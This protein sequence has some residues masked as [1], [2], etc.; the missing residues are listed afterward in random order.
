MI[1]K[2]SSSAIFAIIT[3][4]ICKSAW[5]EFIPS[6]IKLDYPRDITGGI[7]DPEIA[8]SRLLFAWTNQQR[9][10]WVGRLSPFT[11]EIL[12]DQ[13]VKVDTNAVPAYA[14]GNG[15]EWVE[16]ANSPSI[17]Y[18]KY[19]ENGQFILARAYLK[20]GQ[21][22]TVVLA[23]SEGKYGPIGN[24][25]YPNNRPVINYL[26]RDPDTPKKQ[27]TY[28]RYLNA[29][30]SE[31]IVP[32]SESPN[33]RWA[34]DPQELVL[35]I[36]TI[37]GNPDYRQ[38][39]SYNINNKQMTQLTFGGESK[40]AVFMWR[41]PEFD[42]QPTFFVLTGER[43]LQIYYLDQETSL[44]T[45]S[46]AISPP[47]S[48]TWLW[49]PEPIVY[50]GRTFIS[51]VASPSDNQK[52]RSIPTEIWLAGIDPQRPF[53]RKLSDDTIAVR[54]DPELFTTRNQLYVLFQRIASEEEPNI[55]TGVFRLNTGF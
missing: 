45:Y 29:P 46:H 40:S 17:I 54:K 43:Y 34:E 25:N 28:W 36:P 52:S 38:A 42:Y 8:A 19:N 7:V 26:G 22:N 48:N 55:G 20:N 14:I 9:E 11:G 31:E 6:E 24:L 37:P 53:Y 21:W 3:L 33:G 18:T 27:T 4:L 5:A 2:N 16:G 10:L 13:F 32:G 35:S 51:M 50:K 23:N 1:R 39:F 15:P 44:W 30:S 41:A 12:A 49:S 47:S